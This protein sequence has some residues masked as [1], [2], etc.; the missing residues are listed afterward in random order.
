M[1]NYPEDTWLEAVQLLAMS[2]AYTWELPRGAL[3]LIMSMNNL[4]DIQYETIRGY[5]EPGRS[6]KLS[7]RFTWN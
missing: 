1:Y 7:T 4:Q 5:P 6:L 2:T 3:D